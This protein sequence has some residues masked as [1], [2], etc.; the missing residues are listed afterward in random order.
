MREPGAN[1][2]Q[3]RQTFGLGQLLSQVG[4]LALPTRKHPAQPCA[5]DHH[6]RQQQAH[7]E[8]QGV[9]RACGQQR[10]AQQGPGDQAAVIGGHRAGSERHGFA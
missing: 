10:H 8:D 3:G 1:A 2:P 4:R 7:R 5:G 6:Q 9:D